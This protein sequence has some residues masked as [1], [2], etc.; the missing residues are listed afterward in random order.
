MKLPRWRLALVAGVGLLALAG[1][2]PE[3]IA[4]FDQITGPYRDVMSNDELGR[5]RACESNDNYQ[6]VSSNGRYRGAYQFS[7]STWDGVAQRHFPWLEGQ[8]PA[9]AEPWWQDAMAKALWSESGARPWPHC[10]AHV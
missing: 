10:G 4:A 3:Q 6:S 8:D 7:Q 2:T 9:G 5:L 1:C